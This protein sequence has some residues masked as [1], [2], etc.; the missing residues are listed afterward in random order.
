MCFAQRNT[1]AQPAGSSLAWLQAD[2]AE[3][4]IG[5]R[6]ILA[7]LWKRASDPTAPGEEIDL[8]LTEATVKPMEFLPIKHDFLGQS[9]A[10]S[11]NV[12]PG[13]DIGQDNDEI[14]GEW[15]GLTEADRAA[16]RE[17]WVI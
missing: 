15:L 9:H 17:R 11:G 13:G 4:L 16:L 10:R 7:A 14:Y 5:A 6:G 8:S 3:R 12:S 1:C 2:S